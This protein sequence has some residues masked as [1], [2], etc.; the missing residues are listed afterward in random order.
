[1]L[2]ETTT[3][4]V[5]LFFFLYTKMEICVLLFAYGLSISKQE[6]TGLAGKNTAHLRIIPAKC[7]KT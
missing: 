2:Y 1:M 6:T 5:D 4:Y 7:A 3:T